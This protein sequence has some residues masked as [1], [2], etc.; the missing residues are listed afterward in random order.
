MKTVADA[1]AGRSLPL[2]IG[3]A[4]LVVVGLV[5]FA[6]VESYRDLETVEARRTE[7]EAR[8]SETEER[9]VELE[10]RR[11]LLE[12]DPATIERLAREELG[13]AGEDERIYV[14]TETPA[15]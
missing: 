9:L 2:L 6:S 14:V 12:T 3:T 4:T 11:R 5:V 13:L 10:Y 15:E 7:L 1:V 8:V